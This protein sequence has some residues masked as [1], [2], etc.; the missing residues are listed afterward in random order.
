MPHVTMDCYLGIDQSLSGFGMSVLAPDGHVT[1]VTAF[2][3]AEFGGGIDRLTKISHWLATQLTGIKARHRVRHVCMEGYSY[4]SAQGREEAGEL[5][6]MVKS[7]LRQ[8][9]E[10]PACYPTIVPPK[11]L[12]KF[13]TGNGNATKEQMLES[14]FTRWDV[15]FAA[16]FSKALAHNAADAYALARFALMVDQGPEDLREMKLRDTITPHTERPQ[17][18]R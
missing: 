11:M 9:L 5:G 10:R 13:A 18:A 7:A 16:R 4:G 8:I 12:K 17:P 6:V 1:T 14:V 15:D 3:A 2:T